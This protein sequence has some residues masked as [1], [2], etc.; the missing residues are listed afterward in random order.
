LSL[1][2]AKLIIEQIQPKI[3]ILTH[4]GMGMWKAKPWEVAQ[5]L[6]E[7][8]G[9]HVIAARDGMKFDLDKL[10]VIKQRPGLTRN[11]I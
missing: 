9:V 6:S 5:R 4:Y 11:K 3:A 2:D 7:E 1:P 8:T 10:E